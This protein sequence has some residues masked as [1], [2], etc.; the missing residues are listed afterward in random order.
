MDK[1]L[2]N[3]IT[4]SMTDTIE[5]SLPEIVESTV[6][7]KVEELASKSASEI[8]E[9]KAELKKMNLTAKAADPVVN[10]FAKKTAVVSIFKDVMNNNVTT[11]A[12]FN[13]IVE[14]TVKTMSEG[15]ATDGAELVFD[16]FETDVL[17]VINTFDIVN[18]TR[19]LPLAKGD[20]VSLPKA[21]NGITTYF[22][23]E[24]IAYTG[25]EADTAFVTIDIAKA[26]TLTDMTQ[27]L[28]DDTMTVPDLYDLIV[29]FIGE[30]QGQFLETQ[31]LTGTGAVKW[32]LVNATVNKIYLGTGNTAEDITDTVLVNVITK[33][34]RKYK[35][36]TSQV[37]FYMS[38][39]VFGK[40]LAL[41]TTD[42]YPL[43]PE[44]RGA[45][46]SLMGYGI[47]MSDVGFVQDVATDIEDGVC[48]LFGDLKYFTLCRRK[49][50]TVERGYYGDNWKKDIQSLKSN[51]R[52]GGTLTFPEALTV[53]IN[54]TA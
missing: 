35:R 23:A 46:P 49:G 20:K 12:G 50:L 44:M 43:Y 25:S 40:I 51:T 21:T 31:I 16:Q 41:K 29:E 4:K 1:E 13:A 10:Q 54:G 53:V 26:A 38:Q 24:G 22:V 27:E 14:K 32:V 15:V 34:A 33:A 18:S 6:S 37:K 52:Y 39:Y 7:K 42:G 8:E 17:R 30:S 36:T 47:V 3:E 9:I 5:K 19:I 2:V 11:E 28:L 45:T 48:L